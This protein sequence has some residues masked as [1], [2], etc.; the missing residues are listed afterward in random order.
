MQSENCRTKF[1]VTGTLRC[2][3]VNFVREMYSLAITRIYAL[4]D[5]KEYIV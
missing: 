4:W 1:Y 3:G 2:I 5:R